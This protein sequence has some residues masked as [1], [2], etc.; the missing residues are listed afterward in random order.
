MYTYEEAKKYLIEHLSRD[1][2]FHLAGDY[3]RVGD[4][5]TEFDGNLPR[6]DDPNFIKLHIALNFWDGWQDSRNHEWRYYKG[7]SQKDWPELAKIIIQNIEG[8]EDITNEII[9]DH[10]DLRRRKSVISKLKKIFK[11]NA[12]A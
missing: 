5:F 12:T 1:I 10:F 7:I 3:S 6:T 9:L 2:A 8:E 4:A 11:T